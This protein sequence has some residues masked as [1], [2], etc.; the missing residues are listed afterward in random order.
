MKRMVVVGFH[1]KVI[2]MIMSIPCLGFIYHKHEKQYL[3]LVVYY[4]TQTSTVK[5]KTVGS[6]EKRAGNL[7]LSK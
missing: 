7:E 4:D 5:F 3:I 1:I 2:R 6:L